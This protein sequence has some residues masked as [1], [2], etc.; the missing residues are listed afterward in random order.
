[1]FSGGAP[2]VRRGI[3]RTGSRSRTPASMLQRNGR[4]MMKK[5]S[6]ARAQE[7]R[8]RQRDILRRRCR[9]YSRF[10]CGPSGRSPARTVALLVSTSSFVLATTVGGCDRGELR[11]RALF[12]A[13]GKNKRATLRAHLGSDLG[14]SHGLHCG[15]PVLAG[16]RKSTGSLGRCN[17][18]GLSPH[19]V[20]E[21]LDFL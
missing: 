7:K 17:C 5:K 3:R 10:L 12:Q 9:R 14:C 4:M 19:T 16:R 13:S 6:R 11:E 15:E 2:G 20:T 18:L 8:R 21:M 1:M